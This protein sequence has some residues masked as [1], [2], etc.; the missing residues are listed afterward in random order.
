MA[1]QIDLKHVSVLWAS[2]EHA[3]DIARCH[4]S[5]FETPWDTSAIQGLLSH[6]GSTAL[7]ARVG[8][9]QQTAGFILGQLAADE[10]EILSFGV[11]KEF[12]R[13]GIGKRLIDGLARAAK[14]AEAKR[15]FLEVADDNI[16]ALVLYSR[17]GFKEVGRRK[18]YYQRA[19]GAKADALVLAL[20]L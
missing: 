16:P 8:H 17:S 6:P 2:I 12:Q 10:A 7:I 14:R 3:E 9:P 5:L 13:N 4:A 19:N 15:L 20:G 11:A 18:G 1:G